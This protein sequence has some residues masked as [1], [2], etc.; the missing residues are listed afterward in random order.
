M[1]PWIKTRFTLFF[2]LR[3]H[4]R[5]QRKYAHD[6]R[7]SIPGSSEE[8]RTKWIHVH[9]WVRFV[10]SQQDEIDAIIRFKPSF[11]RTDKEVQ[12]IDTDRG[13][14]PMWN[15]DVRFWSPPF[16]MLLRCRSSTLSRRRRWRM[17]RKDDDEPFS[18]RRPL[19][20]NNQI[21][22]LLPFRFSLSF[23]FFLILFSVAF[24]LVFGCRDG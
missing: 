16:V 24:F 10:Q 19:I 7:V 12:A 13:S 4:E 22:F 9:N 3:N 18:S 20:G 11:L 1:H 8:F 21:S 23:C 14:L 2:L 6:I 15:V 5:K 17:R